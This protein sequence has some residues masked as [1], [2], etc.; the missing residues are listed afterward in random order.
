[1]YIFFQKQFSRI[2][3]EKISI[4]TI[5]AFHRGARVGRTWEDG[6]ILTHCV[7]WETYEQAYQPTKYRDDFQ[8]N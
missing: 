3:A 8:L 6:F 2:K 4:N 5:H 7:E 1:M